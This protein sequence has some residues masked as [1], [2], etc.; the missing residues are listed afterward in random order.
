MKCPEIRQ[1]LFD[2]RRQLTRISTVLKYTA[3]PEI[4]LATERPY[5]SR[6]IGSLVADFHRN[7]LKGGVLFYPSTHKSPKGKLRL[8]YECNPLAFII[9]GR[10]VDFRRLPPYPRRSANFLHQR[11]PLFIGSAD[12]VTMAESTCRATRRLPPV[13]AF[14]C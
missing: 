3:L 13:K 10:P 8:L 7:L 5:S 9:E 6:Y 12:M 1:D 11:T 4:D 2:Q 14:P